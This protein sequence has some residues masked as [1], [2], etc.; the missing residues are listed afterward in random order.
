M[1]TSEKARWSRRAAMA[2]PSGT[3]CARKPDDSSRSTSV[4]QTS[5]SSSTTRISG[6]TTSSMGFQTAG[7]CAGHSEF[8]QTYAHQ[9]ILNGHIGRPQLAFRDLIPLPIH[10]CMG[11]G[12][13]ALRQR[14]ALGAGGS[15]GSARLWALLRCV[16]TITARAAADTGLPSRKSSICS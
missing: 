12:G 11:S 4:S 8:L 7:R 5:G 16:E 14:A 9:L 15:T 6:F 1:I 13:F 10:T 2:R 3:A